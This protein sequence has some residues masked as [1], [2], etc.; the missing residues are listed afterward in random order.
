MFYTGI[1][2]KIYAQLLFDIQKYKADIECRNEKMLY[3]MLNVELHIEIIN[4]NVNVYSHELTKALPIGFTLAEF[5][6][7]LTSNPDITHLCLLNKNMIN[8]VSY[9]DTTSQKFFSSHYGTRLYL[10]L[11]VLLGLLKMDK[12]T[13][14]ACASIWRD[15]E[16][17]S[18]NKSCNV[19]LQFIIR[20]NTLDLIVISRSSDFLT[21]LQIDSFHWQ[22]LLIL[23]YNELK[24]VYDDLVVGE[25][26]YKITSLHVYEKDKF[27]FDNISLEQVSDYSYNLDIYQTFL[28]LRELAPRVTSCR[29]VSELCDI[30]N[31]NEYQLQTID[32]LKS[33]YKNRMHILQR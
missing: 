13:R 6:T 29:L 28:H 27:I 1:F 11:P 7:I 10:Q 30:Y 17:L 20:K 14:Q 22:A 3:E 23:F 25:V 33:I 2:S 21:G 24:V 26:I 18:K 19:F 31:F 4:N 12:H 15:D 16:L 32:K 9:F 5:L 8:Y